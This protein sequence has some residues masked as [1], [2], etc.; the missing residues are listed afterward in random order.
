MQVYLFG[1]L[2][3]AGGIAIAASGSDIDVSNSDLLQEST[4]CVS[5]LLLE[6]FAH[7][8]SGVMRPLTNSNVLLDFYRHKVRCRAATSFASFAAELSRSQ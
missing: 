8:V 2:C 6:F 7:D 3:K 1:L 4:V 5:N